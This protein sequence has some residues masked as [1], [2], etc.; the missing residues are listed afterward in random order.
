MPQ[1]DYK[2][3]VFGKA[4]P[5]VGVDLCH[6]AAEYSY[7]A[8]DCINFGVTTPDVAKGDKFGLHFV[9][10]ET[11]TTGSS[12]ASLLVSIVTGSSSSPTTKLTSRTF[13]L[14]DL[15]AGKHYYIPCYGKVLQYLGFYAEPNT[16]TA[17][18]GQVSAWF[19]PN[20]DGAE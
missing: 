13:L 14:A 6:A 5:T 7:T 16:G 9:I 15:A 18:A 17:T 2:L 8:E 20:S 12:L 4:V 10:N 3:W 1:S 11:F 19:G